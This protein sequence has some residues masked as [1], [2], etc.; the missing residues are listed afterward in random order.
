V[1]HDFRPRRE[2]SVRVADGR[3]VG[4]AE[5]GDLLGRPVVAFHGGPGSRLFAIGCEQFADALGLRIICLE[6]PGFGLSEFAADRTLLGWVDDVADAT[7]ALDI[8]R[9]VV[10]GVSAGSP[11]ALACGA[12][13]S[14]RVE[15]IGVIAGLAPPGFSVEDEFTALVE[16]DRHDAEAAARRHFEAVRADIDASVR[17]M[18]TPDGP[19]RGTYSRPDVQARFAMTRREAFRQG[20]DGAVLDLILVHQPWG[21]ELEDITINTHWWHGSRDRI[22]PLTTIREATA[23]TRIALSIYE[24]E[25]HAIGFTH[26]AEILATLIATQET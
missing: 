13:P 15:A 26:G 12:R 7:R 17:A 3:A 11:Y 4:F 22:A 5:W 25:G 18:G 8:D 19:D 10:V 16:R 14:S 1:D 23:S 20:V 2:G 24:D 9:F 6:R 21:F